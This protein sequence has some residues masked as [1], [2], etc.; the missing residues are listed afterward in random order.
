MRAPRDP[1]WVADGVISEHW[2]PQ[3]PVTGKID[4][5]QWRVPVERVGI[6]IEPEERLAPVMI[7]AEPQPIEE[8]EIVEAEPVATDVE[9]VEPD[10]ADAV[11]ESAEPAKADPT[12]EAK[13]LSADNDQKPA[14]DSV[15]EEKVD[16]PVRRLPDDPGVPPEERKA[17]SRFR[18]F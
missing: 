14:H 3:S 11:V 16:E 17:G 18:L 7:E 5:F 2:A 4:A 1:A 12:E 6:A 10:E 9:L 8:A 15:Q 13:P